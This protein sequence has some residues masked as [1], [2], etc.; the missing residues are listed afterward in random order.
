[1]KRMMKKILPFLLGMLAGYFARPTIEAK[2]EEME[3][4]K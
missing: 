3:A 4:K 2:I 1:M